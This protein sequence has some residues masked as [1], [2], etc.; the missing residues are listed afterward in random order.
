MFLL[1]HS[2]LSEALVAG[3]CS[4]QIDTMRTSA[5]CSSG[6]FQSNDCSTFPLE[7]PSRIES[8]RGH[9]AIMVKLSSDKLRK[10]RGW[11]RGRTMTWISLVCRF[12]SRL[13]SCS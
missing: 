3:R 4:L 6:A 10:L 2:I 9:G 8:P 5:R 13:A 7:T 1:F 12:R 11:V